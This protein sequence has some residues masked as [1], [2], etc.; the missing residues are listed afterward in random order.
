M[1]KAVGYKDLNFRDILKQ[2]NPTEVQDLNQ[3]EEEEEE[4]EKKKAQ[5]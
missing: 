4:E 1:F 2:I 3:E 5:F